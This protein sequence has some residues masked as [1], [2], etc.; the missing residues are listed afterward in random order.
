MENLLPL[1]AFDWGPVF[2]FFLVI[3]GGFLLIT[4]LFGLGGHAGGAGE[5]H[6]DSH[7]ATDLH[8]A[9]GHD[10]HSDNNGHQTHG[11]LAASSWLSLRFF[12]YFF[13]GFGAI[14]TILT[15]ANHRGPT[16][17]V[18]VALVGGILAGVM[19]QYTLR[20][21]ARSGG[22]GSPR[23]EDYINKTSRVT[24]A[25]MPQKVGEVAVSVR[26]T[27]QSVAAKARRHDDQ[28]K[29]GDRVVITSISQGRAEVISLEEH[30]FVTQTQ[31]ERA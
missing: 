21:L 13:A 10:V 28:F 17:T 1:A 15:Y 5:L 14:G 16:L 6:F 18:P 3:G 4:T 30:E 2:L 26:G 27:E 8:V 7:A 23:I 19:V 12:I 31:G 22:D 11:T 29:V 24:V 25:I 9:D 20:S